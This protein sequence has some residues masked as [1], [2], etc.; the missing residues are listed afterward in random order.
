MQAGERQCLLVSG[1]HEGGL[2]EVFLESQ[3]KM[4]DRQC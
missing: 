2:K 3:V 1:Y 4:Q